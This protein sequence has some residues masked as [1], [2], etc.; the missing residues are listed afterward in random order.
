MLLECDCR[1]DPRQRFSSG[2]FCTR[3]VSLTPSHV[4]IIAASVLREQRDYGG[5]GGGGDALPGGTS[6]LFISAAGRL[7][8]VPASVRVGCQ[9]L[10][11]TVGPPVVCR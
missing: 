3:D 11:I 4:L 10:L 8:R 6:L 9:L 5:G 1:H 7:R 2:G